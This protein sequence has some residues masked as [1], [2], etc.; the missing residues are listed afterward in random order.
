MIGFV[1]KVFSI[2]SFIFYAAHPLRVAGGRREA[3]GGATPCAGHQSITV[4]IYSYLLI[5][6]FMSFFVIV[7]S[8]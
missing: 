4:E 8:H 6:Y 7:Y 2:R 3:G 1:R 5:V